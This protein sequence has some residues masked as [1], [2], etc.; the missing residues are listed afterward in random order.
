MSDAE[1]TH[2]PETRRLLA[3][4][5]KALPD[6]LDVKHDKVTQSGDKIREVGFRGPNNTTRT[7]DVNVSQLYATAPSTTGN[8][9]ILRIE[10]ELVDDGKDLDNPHVPV[11][12]DVQARAK[13]MIES[14]GLTPA[15]EV[16]K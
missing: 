11:N 10:A 2:S 5:R 6:D 9:D 13:D 14:E 8:M 12:E 4:R 1:L 15:W 16:V 3:Q 7:V